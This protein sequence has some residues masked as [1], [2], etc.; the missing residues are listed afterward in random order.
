MSERAES[1]LFLLRGD[2]LFSGE[3]RSDLLLEAAF[4]SS[5]VFLPDVFVC[6]HGYG[7]GIQDAPLGMHYG[8][9]AAMWWLRMVAGFDH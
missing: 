7:G 3:E 1:K 4:L 8:E 2:G 6:L 5:G 9:D